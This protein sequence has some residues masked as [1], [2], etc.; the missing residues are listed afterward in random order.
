MRAILGTSSLMSLAK[1][2]QAML[3]LQGTL[4]GN[5]AV[6]LKAIFKNEP[7]PFFTD[8]LFFSQRPVCSYCTGSILKH[9]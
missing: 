2:H 6:V 3:I 4:F 9:A 5:S 7:K 1:Q 8:V